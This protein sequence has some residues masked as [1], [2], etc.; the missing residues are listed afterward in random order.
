MRRKIR[1]DTFFKEIFM[2]VQKAGALSG[3]RAP[4]DFPNVL[5]SSLQIHRDGSWYGWLPLCW[6]PSAALRR[7]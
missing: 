5:I 1:G 6:E 2:A 4:A 7:S 3:E